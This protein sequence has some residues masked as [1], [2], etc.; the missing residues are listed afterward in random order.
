MVDPVL[1]AK[2]DD[3]YGEALQG[4]LHKRATRHNVA[5]QEC[6]EQLPMPARKK[7]NQVQMEHLW[8]SSFHTANI[9][10]SFKVP[11]QVMSVEASGLNP[12]YNN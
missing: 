6:A 2:R 4:C 9:L 7:F 1:S 3:A 10:H 12:F 8:I 5:L 11:G